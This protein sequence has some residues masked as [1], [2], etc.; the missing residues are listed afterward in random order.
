MV[1]TNTHARPA[2]KINDEKLADTEENIMGMKNEFEEDPMTEG[3]DKT[4]EE[5]ESEEGPLTEE[6][7]TTDDEELMEEE[8]YSTDDSSD[9]EEEE[10]LAYEE[11][12]EEDMTNAQFFEKLFAKL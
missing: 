6:A 7:D 2:R 4:D 10:N 11:E 1:Y 12:E 8:E 5:F 3:D 9:T